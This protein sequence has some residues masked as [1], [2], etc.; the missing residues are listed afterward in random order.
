MVSKSS[1][2]IEFDFLS[3]DLW[4]RRKLLPASLIAPLLSLLFFAL[5][6]DG[7]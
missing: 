6:F 7:L 4:P 2:M 3:D 5:S 1:K